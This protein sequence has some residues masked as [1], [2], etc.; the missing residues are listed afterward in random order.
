MAA[1]VAGPSNF[2]NAEETVLPKPILP[3]IP[4]F[5][6]LEVAGVAI[7]VWNLCP[8]SPDERQIS[9]PRHGTSIVDSDRVGAIHLDVDLPHV[10]EENDVVPLCAAFAARGL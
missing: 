6:A 8:F 3:A 2:R 10:I 4:N 7:S 1:Y 5:E 9:C